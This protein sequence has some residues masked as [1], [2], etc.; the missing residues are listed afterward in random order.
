MYRNVAMLT[1]CGRIYSGNMFA[2]L[3]HTQNQQIYAS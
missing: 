1:I 2:S 3:N